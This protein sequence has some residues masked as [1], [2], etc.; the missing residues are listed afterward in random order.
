MPRK[1]STPDGRAVAT[2]LGAL[3]VGGLMGGIGLSHGTDAPLGALVGAVLG[4]TL[5]R[6]VETGATSPVTVFAILFG[7]AAG[8]LGPGFDDYT[9][10]LMIPAAGLGAFMG[11]LFF[12]F[13][14]QNG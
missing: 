5:G 8:M 9:G 12:G 4:G 13:G 7:L 14:R 11:W 1:Q 3:V 2:I 10:I 6:G